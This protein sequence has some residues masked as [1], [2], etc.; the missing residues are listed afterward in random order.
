MPAMSA[1][2]VM[3][4][5][6]EDFDPTETAVP[7]KVL[8]D[9]GIEVVFA[10]P[11]GKPGAC[12]P[13][14]LEGVVFKQI[15]A[16]KEDA[17]IYAEMAADPAFLN[18]IRYDEIKVEDYAALHLPGGHAPGMVP[19]LESEMLQTKVADFFIADKLV[20]A[21]CHGPVVLARTKD[22]RT[23]K[24]VLHGRRLTALTK[25]LEGS[26]YMLTMWTLGKRFRTYPEY[27]QDEIV[28]A[29]GDKSKFETGPIIPSYSNPFV[30]TDGNLL[31][32]RW[33]GDA[34]KLGEALLDRLQS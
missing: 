31:T 25:L 2:L 9:G 33:P 14:S 6:T 29:V 1:R 26:G 34:R 13:M 20:S 22:P 8:R 18:P 32:A 21:V 5:P 15:G 3:P 24:S 28:A 16:T 7:W 27:V 11:D 17:A 10:T 12:D 30:V 19:Y 23:G 4:L